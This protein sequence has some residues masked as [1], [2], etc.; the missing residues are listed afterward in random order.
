MKHINFVKG[1]F[2]TA[3]LVLSPIA[4]AGNAGK[5]DVIVGYDAKPGKAEKDRVRGLGGE[6]KRE[7]TNFN[8][9]VISISENALKN[10]GKGKGVKFV[11]ADQPVEGFSASAQQTARQPAP[12]SAN[13]F[14]VNGDIG[15]AVL[16][17][18]VTEHGDLNV[19]FRINCLQGT[20]GCVLQDTS[21]SA[22]AYRDEF[23]S[24][25]YSGSVG[26]RPWDGAWTEIGDGGSLS[27]GDV[28]VV[29]SPNCSSG[30]CVRIGNSDTEDQ[31]TKGLVRAIDLSEEAGATLSFDYLAENM[32]GK[33]TVYVKVSADGGASWTTLD[34]Y[35]AY[36]GGSSASFDLSPFASADTQIR[37]DVTGKYAMYLYVDNVQ[38]TIDADPHD[39]FGHGTH[40]A[41]IIGGIGGISAGTYTGVANDAS[42]HSVRVLDH[43]GKGVT[44]DVIA[45]LDW[46]LSNG[47]TNKI[48]VVNLSLGKGIEESNTT[49]PLVLAVEQVWDAGYVVVASAGNYGRDGN[50]TITSPGN[51]RKIITVGSLTDNGT[52]NDFSDDYVST[53]SSMGPTLG[54]H[55]L[56]PDLIA[57]GNRLVATISGKSRL[58]QDL[59]ERVRDCNGACPAEY[60]ELSGTSMAAAMVSGTAA[61]ML[62]NDPSLSPATIKARLMRSARKI[63]ADPVTSGAG[64]LDVSAALAETGTVTG[65]ALSPRMMRNDTDDAIFV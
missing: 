23:V 53:F 28:R 61:L 29:S 56:K 9:R 48:R 16:D 21:P 34:S 15:I 40:V 19:K 46:V 25:A 59:A 45:G 58:K 52:G 49:D 22:N 41:G 11:V 54:D 51:S 36:S 14:P 31:P 4:I 42:I 12:G 57:P 20:A 43:E 18:G 8:M 55:V 5:V 27:S 24:A 65:Q 38:I 33:G 2:I 63:D 1:I 30:Y 32:D 39:P 10:V 26:S 17:T 13:A 60:L 37:F 64:V 47:E 62:T 35:E 44:S 50:M 3:A 6:T 7:F